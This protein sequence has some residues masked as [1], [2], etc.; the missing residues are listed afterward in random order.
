M[1]VY[2]DIVYRD[3][4]WSLNGSTWIIPA[5]YYSSIEGVAP[6]VLSHDCGSLAEWN[7]LIDQMMDDLERLRDKGTAHYK[8]LYLQRSRTWPPNLAAARDNHSSHVNRSDART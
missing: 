7:H 1:Q 5:D 4:G 2:F 3:N 8:A 6:V